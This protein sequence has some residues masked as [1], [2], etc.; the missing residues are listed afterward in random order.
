MMLFLLKIANIPITFRKKKV[1]GG[2][3]RSS[4]EKMRIVQLNMVSASTND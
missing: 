2:G 4:S 3:A 1:G